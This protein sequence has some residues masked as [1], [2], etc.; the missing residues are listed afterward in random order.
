M[1]LPS[2]TLRNSKGSPLTF[3]E[4][5]TNL[6]NLQ[7]AVIGI[8]TGSGTAGSLNLNDTLT[9]QSGAGIALSLNTGTK[10]LTISN[11][12]TVS[13]GTGLT[14]SG[15]TVS[16]NTAT[17]STIGGIKVGANLTITADGTLSATASG[18]GF[19]GTV[20]TLTATN[21]IVLS[22]IT[23]TQSANGSLSATYTTSTTSSSGGVAANVQFQARLEN[24]FV[25]DAN[26]TTTATNNGS[27]TF[28]TASKFSTYSLDFGTDASQT[29]KNILFTATNSL[30]FGTS[31]DFT[32]EGWIYT[33]THTIQAPYYYHKIVTTNTFP[34]SSKWFAFNDNGSS[35][36]LFWGDDVNSLY[37]TFAGAAVV[38]NDQWHHVVAM[39]KAGSLYLGLNGTMTRVAASYSNAQDWTNPR[40]GGQQSIG[41]IDSIRIA[42]TS[43]YTTSTYTVP[44]AEF[45]SGGSTVTTSTVSALPFMPIAGGTMTGTMVVKGFTE[46]VYNWGNVTGTIQPDATSAT[47]HRMTLTGNITLNTVTNITTGSN[48]KFIMTQDATGSRTLTNTGWKWL[49]GSKTLTTTASSIDVITVFYD[50]TNYIAQ[51]NKAY[52]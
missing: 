15:T 27:V 34:T 20:A 47:I 52:S 5:D 41:K 9:I 40:I 22:G 6:Q 38:A 45:S 11:T 48:I 32:I 23:L 10:T 44:T 49:G 51:L 37:Y 36:D 26:A 13:A 7:T 3:T 19:T 12:G 42:N 25:D 18:S 31:G 4:M 17:T 33:P 21:S 14:Q 29:T 28:A 16:L 1:A 43:V 24:N 8:T 35:Y 30:N 2:L 46:T 50:G 39:R